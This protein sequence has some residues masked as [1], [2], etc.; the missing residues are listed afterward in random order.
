M[1]RRFS[2]CRPRLASCLDRNRLS[3]FTPSASPLSSL[4]FSQLVKLRCNGESV[5][6]VST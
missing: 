3:E 6:Y 2:Y 4:P 5:D 1:Q